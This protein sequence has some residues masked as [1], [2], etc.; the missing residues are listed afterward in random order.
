MTPPPCDGRLV[1]NTIHGDVV[2][3]RRILVALISG[4]AFSA[5]CS[6][7]DDLAGR[8]QGTVQIPGYPVHATVDFDRD[9]AGAWIGSIVIA[10]LAVKNVALM[11]ITQNGDAVTFAI[12]GALAAASDQPAKFDAHLSGSALSG[13]FTQAGN[14]APFEFKRVGAA[15]VELPPAST[16][17]AKELVGE[18]KGDYELMGYARHVTVRFANHANAPASAEF[19][20]VGKKVNNLPVDLLTQD[21]EFLRIESHEFGINLDGRFRRDAGEIEAVYQQGPFE[22]P[23]VLRR[24]SGKAK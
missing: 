18:W 20:I 4:C 11:P 16:P 6:A 23:F 24:S 9:R 2:M 17:V 13:T 1:R 8:W 3:P 15:Q 10:E 5:A 19:V 21:G 22:V 14:T 7:A 12:K